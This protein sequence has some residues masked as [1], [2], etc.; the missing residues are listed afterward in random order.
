MRDKSKFSRMLTTPVQAALVIVGLAFGTATACAQEGL[1]IPPP[2]VDEAKSTADRE[3]ALFAGGCFWG[4]QG[5]FQRVNGVTNAVSGYAGG[6]K[7]TAVYDVVSHGKTEHAESVRITFDPRKVSYGRLLQIYFS[8][9]HDPTQLN[10]QG[11]DKGPQY[12]S[13]GENADCRR[14]ASLT[15]SAA[16]S[17][18][19]CR[20]GSASL[21]MMR[22][23]RSSR[24][25]SS[26][27]VS[28][29]RR[30]SS[31][32]FSPEAARA[33]AVGTAA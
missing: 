21:P 26:S 10:R 17:V 30:S 13:T 28:R 2:V 31:H 7:D 20:A 14:N 32:S 6:D 12:R 22:A 11:P 4:V 5:V 1:A 9:A 3:T 18:S 24:A 27:R 8:A 19:R 15:S 16:S 25:C 33:R 29:R 23:I